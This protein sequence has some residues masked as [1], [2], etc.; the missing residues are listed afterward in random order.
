MHFNA[1]HFKEAGR[2]IFH[3]LIMYC[4]IDPYEVMQCKKP[5]ENMPAAGKEE[6]TKKEEKE[7]IFDIKMDDIM[8]EFKDNEEELLN[9]SDAGSSAGSDSEPSEDNMSDNE[10][11]KI[12]PVK[13]KKKKHNKIITQSSFKKRQRE[14]EK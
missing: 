5:V 9:Q 10:I 6:D 8:N 12:L 14:L 2:K 3:A 11:S 13:V 7:D 4:K 1:E